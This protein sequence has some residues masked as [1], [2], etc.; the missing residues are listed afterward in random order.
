MERILKKLPLWSDSPIYVIFM[1]AQ[2]SNNVGH[3]FQRLYRPD[4]NLSRD[5]RFPTMWHFDLETFIE[6]KK[7][8]GVANLNETTALE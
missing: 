4:Y 7:S 5:M 1:V 6:I 3:D 2:L 8:A